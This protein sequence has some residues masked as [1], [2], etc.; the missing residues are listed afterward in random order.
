MNSSRIKILRS[1]LKHTQGPNEI[2]CYTSKWKVLKAFCFL[3]QNYKN[4]L[5]KMLFKIKVPV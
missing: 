4:Y 3:K 1:S 5:I 2:R